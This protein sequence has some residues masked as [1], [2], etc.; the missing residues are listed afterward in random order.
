MDGILVPISF[1]ACIVLII[2]IF[3]TS[4]NKERLALIEKGAD[5]SLFKIKGAFSA[6]LKYGMFLMGVGIGILV[7]NIVA[8]STSLEEVVAYFSMILLFGGA[9]L[10]AYYLIEKK[11]A[12]KEEEE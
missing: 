5:A 12:L 4:R 2:Y 10:I 11:K 1:F 8:V 3:F 7:G 6:T 9:S